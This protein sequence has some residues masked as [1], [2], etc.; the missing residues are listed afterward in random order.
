MKRGDTLRKD[1]EHHEGINLLN[2]MIVNQDPDLSDHVIDT[3]TRYSQDNQEQSPKK[4][5]NQINHIT[6]INNVIR[7]A[8]KIN[9]ISSFLDYQEQFS[10][11][12]AVFA[13]HESWLN[14]VT[15]NSRKYLSQYK[16]MYE[17]YE[18]GE[19]PMTSDYREEIINDLLNLNKMPD[20]PLEK[21]DDSLIDT[22]HIMEAIKDVV[23]KGN[24]VNFKLIQELQAKFEELIDHQPGSNDVQEELAKEN[25][26]K[27]NKLIHLVLD[28]FDQLDLIFAQTAKMNDEQWEQ[29]SGLAVEKALKMLNDYGIEEIPVAGQLFNGNVMEAIG[30]IS[31]QE[32]QSEIDIYHV[33]AVHQR[34]FRY[35]D[36]GELIRRAR[37]TTVL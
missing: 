17:L 6:R 14:Q 18:K 5:T 35:R 15:H 22:N 4:P 7:N 30:T 26:K 16:A 8:L 34:G 29:Q 19:E 10:K 11:I 32:T 3:V 21:P 1:E 36:C 2:G 28:T 37:V 24:R 13:E 25:N 20:F 31:Q 33:Y 12:T 23:M 9:L 27:M